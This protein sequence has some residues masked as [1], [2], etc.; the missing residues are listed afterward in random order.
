MLTLLGNRVRKMA[1]FA[2]LILIAS[3]CV[4]KGSVSIGIYSYY[5]TDPGGAQI[6]ARAHSYMWLYLCSCLVAI[7]SAVWLLPRALGDL[8]NEMM[9]L[10][11]YLL[12]TLISLF[13]VGG[14]VAVVSI[15]IAHLRGH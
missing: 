12:S 5:V 2:A 11:K 4:L 10:V 9:P 13:A 15:L 6:A 3:W 1:S 14:T 8:W 7:G